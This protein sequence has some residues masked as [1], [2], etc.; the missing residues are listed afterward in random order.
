MA[1]PAF[2]AMSRF[3]RRRY[4]ECVDLCSEILAENP[5]DKAIWLLKTQALTAMTFIDDSDLEE[6]G[7]ADAVM[8]DNATASMPR[9]GTS[10]N[11][12]NASGK[13]SSLDRVMRPMSNAGRPNSGFVRPST[14]NGMRPGTGE[15]PGSRA[16]L[17]SAMRKTG[18]SRPGTS[19][20]VT[21]LGRHVR[22]GT[23]SMR[24]ESDGPFIDVSRMDL[25]KYAHRPT[26]ARALCEFLLYHDH[27]ARKALELAAEATSA[28]N[29]EDWFWKSRLGKC[30][31]L[32]GLYRDAEQ[33]FKSSLRTQQSVDTFLD[34]GKVYLRLDQPQNALDAY[35]QALEAFPGSTAV[36]TA[37]ART[38]EMMRDGD[39]SLRAFK[40]VLRHDPSHVEAIASLGAH[41]FYSDQPEIALRFYRRLLE[42]TQSTESA[43]GSARSYASTELW[44]NVALCCFHS[45]QY[46]MTMRC[47]E[48]ALASADD[49]NMAD[50]WFNVGHVGVSLGDLGFAYQCFKVAV[51]IDPQHV[52]A[53]NNLGVLEVR[54]GNQEDAAADFA[55]ARS[56]GSFAYEPCFNGALLA[57]KRGDFPTSLRLAEASRV[58]FSDHPETL[59]LVEMLR[60]KLV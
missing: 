52:E 34:L 2:L 32:L 38:Y 53:Y 39:Q 26:L 58:L 5:Y 41:Y 1:S 8:D 60:A 44:N 25:Q 56:A 3:R 45:G 55:Q 21:A 35:A 27:N 31:Y 16:A 19:R 54:K 11:G 37:K 15:T 30:Y 40:D 22:L 4:E 43:S 17:E 49:S 36:L 6:L 50:V 29:F 46:D 48:N 18:S 42:I 13:G 28:C 20:P 33:Q 57:Y 23:A 9:P 59:E 12:D 14:Q 47:F 24:A 51:S 10:L 7:I